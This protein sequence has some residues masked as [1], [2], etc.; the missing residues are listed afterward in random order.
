MKAKMKIEAKN[1]LRD[2]QILLD[3]LESALKQDLSAK[4]GVTVNEDDQIS[5][6]H[7]QSRLMSDL[8]IKFPG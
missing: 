2:E 6:V 5:I 4:G 8:F 7:F 3:S 1:G